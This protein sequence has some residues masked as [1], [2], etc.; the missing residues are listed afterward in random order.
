VSL[1][2]FIR[3]C[4][5]I[6]HFF[7]S[8]NGNSNSYSMRSVYNKGISYLLFCAFEFD[9]K[10]RLESS[11]SHSIR[12]RLHGGAIFGKLGISWRKVSVTAAWTRHRLL[13]SV[14]IV[15]IRL[16]THA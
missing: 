8:G 6:G 12:L 3:Q 5:F 14:R 10:H 13:S 1:I 7:H 9:R 16:T 2:Y 4:M 11:M 15:F